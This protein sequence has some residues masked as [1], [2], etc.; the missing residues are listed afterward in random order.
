[1]D[2]NPS[3]TSFFSSFANSTIRDPDPLRER[4]ER[5][6]RRFKLTYF[7]MFYSI[8]NLNTWMNANNYCP[9]ELV[10]V[11]TFPDV[12]YFSVTDNDMH[13]AATQHLADADMDP[14]GRPGQLLLE[15]VHAGHTVQRHSG[16]P[17]A[18]QLGI[19]TK[20]DNGAG[21]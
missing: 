18:H 14:V 19:R 8:T 12:R 20:L 6:F 7:Q 5:Q 4:N 10:I 15:P 3:G 11:G 13:Y 16:I 17:C 1:V 9:V 2:T 21:M